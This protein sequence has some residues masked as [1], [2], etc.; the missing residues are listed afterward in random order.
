MRDKIA[1]NPFSSHFALRKPLQKYGRFKKM[2]LPQR[3]RLFFRAFVDQKVI[4]MLWLGFPCRLKPFVCQLGRQKLMIDDGIKYTCKY[5]YG[6]PY[7]RLGLVARTLHL[8]DF[9]GC[10]GS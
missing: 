7:S 6:Y 3:Y 4:I 9:D 10:L 1:L 2:G 5:N 8:V